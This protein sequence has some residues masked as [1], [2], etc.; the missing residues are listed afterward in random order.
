[1]K[2]FFFLLFEL[3]MLK[4][5][6]LLIVIIFV[7]IS[8]FIYYTRTDLNYYINKFE[9]SKSTNESA[10]PKLEPDGVYII[11][12]KF[13]VCLNQNDIL[14]FGFVAIAPHLFAKR[15][16]IRH[17]WANKTIFPDIKLVFS[18]GLSKNESINEQIKAESSI[19]NDV[20][21]LN[22]NDSYEKLTFKVLSTFKWMITYCSGA[23]YALRINDDVVLNTFAFNSFLKRV[24][25]NETNTAYGNILYN[26]IVYR[27]FGNKF[28][29]SFEQFDKPYFYPYPEGSAYVLTNDLVFKV[30]ELSLKIPPKFPIE[31]AYL[32]IL[33]KE[34]SSNLVNIVDSYVPTNQYNYYSLEYKL[35]LVKTK[36]IDSV[37]FIYEGSRIDY[38]WRHLKSVYN[39][40]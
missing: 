16:L 40:F 20:L 25:R 26:S 5:T 7:L 24:K 4:K 19:H 17:T 9:T 1:M 15:Q 12:P 22:F 14:W 18:I 8:N 6:I 11:N 3:K 31:D 23:A 34:L 28:Y 27:D 10:Q 29:V 35:G 13:S 32:G 37:L 33:L 39:I 30:N 21:Q 2:N 36:D 38:Y